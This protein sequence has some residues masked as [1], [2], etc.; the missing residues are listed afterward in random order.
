MTP[1]RNERHWISVTGNHHR[2]AWIFI[3][4][5]RAQVLSLSDVCIWYNWSP[6]WIFHLLWG[7]G[8]C[9]L[10]RRL[11]IRQEKKP[12]LN[13]GMRTV[14]HLR[15]QSL[16]SGRSST[17]IFKCLHDRKIDFHLLAKLPKIKKVTQGL[18]KSKFRSNIYLNLSL[19]L[20]FIVFCCFRT[21][22]IAELQVRKV[23]CLTLK[24]YLLTYW[25]YWNTKNIYCKDLLSFIFTRKLF[26]VYFK[27]YS[28]PSQ[29][30]WALPHTEAWI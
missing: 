11:W 14:C 4:N 16:R 8:N 21:V 20:W 23:M 5:I 28:W 27:L 1:V 3:A 2:G 15:T 6:Y 26:F 10:L 22:R 29:F 9:L 12:T 24:S 13:V 25:N 17:Y 19:K 7:F 18:I 30:S